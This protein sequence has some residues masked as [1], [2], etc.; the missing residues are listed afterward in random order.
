MAGVLE[1]GDGLPELAVVEIECNTRIKSQ[2][3]AQEGESA[4]YV[5]DRKSVV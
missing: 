3:A 4:V 5:S 1:H 2:G